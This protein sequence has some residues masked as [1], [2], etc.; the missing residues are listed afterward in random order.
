MKK[1]FSILFTAVMI[2]GFAATAQAVPPKPAPLQPV[3]EQGLTDFTAEVNDPDSPGNRDRSS[4]DESAFQ[5]PA[6][7]PEVINEDTSNPNIDSVAEVAMDSFPIIPLIFVV[8][9]S[10]GIAGLYYWYKTRKIR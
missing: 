5:E 1:Y 9:I 6:D 7:E 8:I 10:A 4:E 3:G 2:F